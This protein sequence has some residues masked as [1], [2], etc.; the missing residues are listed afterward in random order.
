MKNFKNSTLGVILIG[1]A[2]KLIIKKNK[3]A[4]EQ[5]KNLKKYLEKEFIMLEGEKKQSKLDWYK[6]L[7]NIEELQ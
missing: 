3:E 6:D 1:E 2:Y 4:K 7:I 5:Y